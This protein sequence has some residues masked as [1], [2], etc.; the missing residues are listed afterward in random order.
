MQQ[1]VLQASTLFGPLCI[2]YK[3]AVGNQ[4]IRLE[5]CW[6]VNGTLG[7]VGE[8]PVPSIG[9]LYLKPIYTDS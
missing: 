7:E 5:R 1:T 8:W 9:Q 3:V 2:S 4:S 6:A